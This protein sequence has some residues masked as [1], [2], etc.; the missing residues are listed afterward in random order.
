M[1][2]KEMFIQAL[3]TLFF[4]WGGDPPPE[5]FWT[6]N[7]LLKW[8]EKEYDVVLGVFF[9]E[10]YWKNDDDDFFQPVIDAIREK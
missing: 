1:N 7:E 4:S 9:D 2:E 3:N 5:A 10:E 6:G 8:Y